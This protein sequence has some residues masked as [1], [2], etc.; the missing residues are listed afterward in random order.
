MKGIRKDSV[1]QH[2]KRKHPKL[3]SFEVRI[4]PPMLPGPWLNASDDGR[5]PDPNADARVVSPPILQPNSEIANQQ[6]PSQYAF[7]ATETPAYMCS[8]QL[9]PAMVNVEPFNPGWGH[10]PQCY[11]TQEITPAS[12]NVVINLEKLSFELFISV[13]SPLYECNM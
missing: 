2:V 6:W 7:C 8:T 4:L 11:P 9:A 5:S 1:K 3:K 13:S 10:V 12:N